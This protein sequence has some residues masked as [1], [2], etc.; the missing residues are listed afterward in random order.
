MSSWKATSASGVHWKKVE[1]EVRATTGAARRLYEPN[2]NE[3]AAEVCRTQT[4]H[5]AGS[6]YCI[7]YTFSAVLCP[8]KDMEG[9]QSWADERGVDLGKE[10]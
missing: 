7:L 2:L 10:G 5:M 9:M 8:R 1:V 4:V 3:P 6:I